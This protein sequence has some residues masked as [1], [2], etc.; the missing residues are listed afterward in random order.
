MTPGT[1]KFTKIKYFNHLGSFSILYC[2]W[3]RPQGKEM[4]RKIPSSPWGL[5]VYYR[6]RPQGKDL[7]HLKKTTKS[8]TLPQGTVYVKKNDQ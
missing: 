2:K 6:E 3:E 4:H 5:L 8:R 7:F 1:R